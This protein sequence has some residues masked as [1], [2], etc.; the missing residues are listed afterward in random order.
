MA[1]MGMCI[2]TCVHVQCSSELEGGV[3]MG[4]FVFLHDMHVYLHAHSVI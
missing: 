1:M 4:N 2:C 3:H